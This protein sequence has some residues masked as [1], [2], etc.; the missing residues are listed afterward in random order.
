MATS[1]RVWR[2]LLDPI[3]KSKGAR[4]PSITPRS[5]NGQGISCVV[6]L[7]SS[8]SLRTSLEVFAPLNRLP[9]T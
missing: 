7:S 6:L 5:S 4:A 3:C 1:P 9:A 8:L 2:P